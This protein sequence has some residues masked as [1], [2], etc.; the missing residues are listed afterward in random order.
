MVIV[1]AE[2]LPAE[3]VMMH[4]VVCTITLCVVAHG[5]TANPWAKRLAGKVTAA[6]KPS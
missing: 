3:S 1:S 5:I 2:N 6:A 4:T